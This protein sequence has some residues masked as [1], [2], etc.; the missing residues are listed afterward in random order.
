M[1]D[2]IARAIARGMNSMAES[3]RLGTME[4]E[5]QANTFE[6]FTKSVIQRDGSAQIT[7][8]RGSEPES[9]IQILAINISPETGTEPEI[10]INLG[11]GFERVEC[12]LSDGR[13]TEVWKRRVEAASSG[14]EPT[15]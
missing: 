6:T 7:V 12:I 11:D 4:A 2:T 1:A 10:V 15:T 9:R 5:A 14:D 8:A 13:Q 3:S